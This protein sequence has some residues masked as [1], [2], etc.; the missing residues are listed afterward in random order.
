MVVIGVAI[1]VVPLGIV[2]KSRLNAGA[3]SSN[4]NEKM[5]PPHYKKI[6]KFTTSV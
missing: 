2:A 4:K 1:V 5:L 6:I 3:G